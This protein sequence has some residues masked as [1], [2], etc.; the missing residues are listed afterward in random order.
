MRNKKYSATNF[1][2]K[3]SAST[4]PAAQHSHITIADGYEVQTH[5]NAYAHL[6]LRGG[7]HQPNYGAE[8]LHEAKAHM[9]HHNVKNPAILVDASH[10]NCIIQGQKDHLRQSHVIMETLDNMA[11]DPVLKSLVKGFMIESFLKDGHQKVDQTNPQS[12]DREGLSITDPC[13]GWDKT[14]SLLLTMAERLRA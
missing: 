14:E 10:D 3:A 7:N 6:V 2:R 12:I 5:G 4:I 1:S 11:Q 9:E 13:L 8:R